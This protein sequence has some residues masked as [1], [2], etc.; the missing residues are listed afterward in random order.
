MDLRLKLSS[1]CVIS[2]PSMSGKTVF[3]NDL[4]RQ[5]DNI[6]DERPQRIVWYYGEISPTEKIKGVTYIKGLPIADSIKEKSVVVLDD[7]MMESS[8]NQDVSNLFTRVA[9]HKNCFVIF[10]TQNLYHQSPHNRT[11]Q[12]S[13]SYL[14][15]FK[16][17]R[18]CTIITTLARQMYPKQGNFLI[19]AFRDATSR[20]HGYLFINLRQ[21]CPE[22]LRIRGNILSDE[23]DVYINNEE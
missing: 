9:H 17:P 16:C 2:G 10:I 8:N 22:N 1:V 18:D 12:L 4:L 20:P 14:I 19:D 5:S 21:E 15:L 6:F 7:L 11:R 3:T 23:I 13:A